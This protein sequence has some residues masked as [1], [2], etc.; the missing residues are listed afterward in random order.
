MGK[1]KKNQSVFIIP[2]I[3]IVIGGIIVYAFQENFGDVVKIGSGADILITDV[4]IKNQAWIDR[5]VNFEIVVFNQGSK[6]AE[7]CIVVFSDGNT[8]EEGKSRVFTLVPNKEEKIPIVTDPYQEEGI[9]QLKSYILCK[10]GS[11]SDVDTRSFE[12][13]S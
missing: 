12:V 1:G 7:T 5:P 9:Y 6:A 11:K 8:V 2:I 13:T 10:D 3:V 4:I